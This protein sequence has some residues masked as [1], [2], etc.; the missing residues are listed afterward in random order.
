MTDPIAEFLAKGGKITKCAPADAS[1]VKEASSRAYHASK[2]L[3]SDT[4]VKT[5][6]HQRFSAGPYDRLPEGQ[7]HDCGHLGEIF[8]NANGEV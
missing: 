8:F 6:R 7:T 1:D 4:E 3:E 5:E 2:A